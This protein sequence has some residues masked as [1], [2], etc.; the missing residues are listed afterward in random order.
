MGQAQAGTFLGEEEYLALERAAAFRSEYFDGGMFAM[1]GGTPAHSL[2][3]TNLGAELRSLLRGRPCRVFNADLRIKVEAAG[4]YTYPDLSVVC[5]P[6]KFAG[7]T[8]DVVTNPGLLAEVLSDA[9]ESYDRGRKFEFYRQLPTLEAY[10][11]ASQHE[12]RLELFVRQADG[13]WRLTEAAGPAA[14]LAVPPLEVELELAEVFAGV[15]FPP[16]V[17]RP[18]VARPA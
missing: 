10:L 2:I 8:L 6:L 14:R 3:A 18:P 12:P 17:L 15:E 7:Q 13:S 5:G 16:Q 1:A 9:T 11:L 4:L